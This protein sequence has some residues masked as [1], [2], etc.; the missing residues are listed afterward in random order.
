[1]A[2]SARVDIDVDLTSLAL[3]RLSCVNM[4]T[5]LLGEY[6]DAKGW[7]ASTAL[8]DSRRKKV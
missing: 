4:K 7:C 2:F 6:R 5:E 1:M 8:R 3:C